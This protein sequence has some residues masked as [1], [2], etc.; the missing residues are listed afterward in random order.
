MM[1]AH[2]LRSPLSV[3]AGYAELI[4]TNEDNLSEDSVLLLQRICNNSR[5]L[6]EMVENIL[7]LGS[8]EAKQTPLNLSLVAIESL[9]ENVLERVE[10]LVEAKNIHLE[11]AITPPHKTYRVDAFKLEQVF[12]NLLTNAVKFSDPNTQVKLTAWEQDDQL[13]FKVQDQG[14]GMTETQ[15]QNAFTRFT[16]F[17]GNR[18]SGSGLG[19]AIVKALVELHGGEVTVASEK[20][21]G[22]CFAFWVQIDPADTE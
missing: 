17:A 21:K 7:S 14:M 11:I 13:H 8:L 19:L 16:R 20:N 10:P 4:E 6:M 12:Q 1:A 9:V 22:S 18:I 5:R 15:C 2:D 3:I